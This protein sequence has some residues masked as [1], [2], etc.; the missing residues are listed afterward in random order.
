MAFC[1]RTPGDAAATP[2]QVESSG[3][4]LERVADVEAEARAAE[5]KLTTAAERFGGVNLSWWPT[6]ARW[7]SPTPRRNWRRSVE[8]GMIDAV[9]LENPRAAMQVP[10]AVAVR[11]DRGNRQRLPAGRSA[12]A[13][14][15]LTARCKAA[16]ITLHA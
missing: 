8:V 2:I 5:V 3:M 10:G 1:A 16:I 9:S 12:F 13:T 6:S 11:V 4:V 14:P 15:S 7:P